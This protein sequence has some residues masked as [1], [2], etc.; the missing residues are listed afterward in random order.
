MQ[1]SGLDDFPREG[2]MD[3]RVDTGTCSPKSVGQQTGGETSLDKVNRL[4]DGSSNLVGESNSFHKV[5]PLK[6]EIA[7]LEEG[8]IPHTVMSATA[9]DVSTVVDVLP[10]HAVSELEK[11]I[12]PVG[13][14]VSQ[15]HTESKL[16]EEIIGP[17]EKQV[18]K[19]HKVSQL[20]EDL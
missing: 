6:E 2:I 14:F 3:S 13:K 11:E 1:L 15:S 20:S 16:I 9:K 5:N 4:P 19:S 8:T 18:S 7:C 10:S 12:S 17:A